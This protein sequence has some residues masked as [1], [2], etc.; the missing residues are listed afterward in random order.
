MN[1]KR[2]IIVI[3]CI[4][5]YFCIVSKVNAKTTKIQ[6]L[7]NQLHSLDDVERE[8][9]VKELSKIGKPAVKAVV[10][11]LGKAEVY[12]G[13]ANAAKVLGNIK[14]KTAV[15][16][17]LKSMKDEYAD[18]RR[19]SAEALGKIHDKRAVKTLIKALSDEVD[20]VKASAAMAL[21]RIGDK[22]AVPYLKGLLK[23][24]DENVRKSAKWAL[25][26]LK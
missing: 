7:V 18:V 11:Y 21:G 25:D 14:D 13:R 12:L 15:P 8:N 4:A 6:Q 10:D 19:L 9:A 2:F 26:R 22:S 24:Q 23:S 20:D 5:F 3:L 16:A 17:L 1:T